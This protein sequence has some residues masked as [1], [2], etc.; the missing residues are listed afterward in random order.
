MKPALAVAVLL[1]A[2]KTLPSTP[3]PKKWSGYC[4]KSYNKQHDFTPYCHLCNYIFAGWQFFCHREV[5]VYIA[6]REV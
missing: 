4:R 5:G 3:Q 6:F 2:D 1:E